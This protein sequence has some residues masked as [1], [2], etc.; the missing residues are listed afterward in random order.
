EISGLR[1][2][3]TRQADGRWNLGTLIKCDAS[4]ENLRGPGRPLH[5][6][7][8]Q[9]S[10]TSVA[11]GEEL[12]FGPA[13]LSTVFEQFAARF[14]FDYE[15]V[16]W[17]LTFTQASWLGRAPDLRVAAMTGTIANAPKGWTL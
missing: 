5:L 7:A 4:E 9:I 10:N 14:S 3:V 13:H 12:T 16:Q 11:I 1:V 15:P 6:K 17:T 2:F 8:V